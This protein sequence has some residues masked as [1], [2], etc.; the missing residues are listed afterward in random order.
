MF[1]PGILE[2]HSGWAWPLGT[3]G[4]GMRDRGF[5]AVPEVGAEV[6]VFFNQGEVCSAGSRILVERSIYKR[7]LDAMVEKAKTI[8]LGNGL[9][10]TGRLGHHGL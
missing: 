5:F 3:C 4:G 6:A 10:P 9:E 7:V 8:R 2:P 1:V